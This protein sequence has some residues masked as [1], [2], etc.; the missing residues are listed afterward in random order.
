MQDRR[1]IEAAERLRKAEPGELLAAE[2]AKL[3]GGVEAT[4]LAEVA[5][6]A[7]KKRLEDE[8]RM[9]AMV[10]VIARRWDQGMHRLFKGIFPRRERHRMMFEAEERDNAKEDA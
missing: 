10:Q 7:E 8:Q 4:D 1:A 6:T 3:T 5:R 9:Q 2:A